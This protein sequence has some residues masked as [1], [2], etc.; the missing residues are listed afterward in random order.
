MCQYFYLTIR[1][2][3]NMSHPTFIY[4]TQNSPATQYRS[5]GQPPYPAPAIA[6]PIINTRLVSRHNHQLVVELDTTQSNDLPLDLVV[7]Y[8]LFLAPRESH[9]KPVSKGSILI[10]TRND[11]LELNQLLENRNYQLELEF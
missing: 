9:P 8:Q 11:T 3:Y 6:H 4:I 2:Y 10:L 5:F 7:E 1:L